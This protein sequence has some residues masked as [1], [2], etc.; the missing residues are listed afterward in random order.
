MRFIHAVPATASTDFF[1][2]DLKAFSN[3]AYKSVTPYSEVPA[4]KHMFRLRLAGQDSAQP[5][6]E[7]TESLNKGTHYTAVALPSAG[8]AIIARNDGTDLLFLVDKFAA[9][10]AGK[11][12][13]RVVHAVPDLGELD[14][15]LAGRSEAV[16]KGIGFGSAVDYAEL[17]PSTAALEVRRAGENVTT[18]TVPQT[19][20]AA[21]KL[22]TV[23]IVGRTK[24]TANLEA[25]IIED[26]LGSA[27]AK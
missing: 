13:L 4:S 11:A 15:Y 19:T 26:Q 17:D 8:T 7:E 23:L 5:L 22:Y 2:G 1:A 21:D 18:L 9:P 25:V 24:G 14:I 10:S 12:K 20:L 16:L 27:P 3:I 6:V